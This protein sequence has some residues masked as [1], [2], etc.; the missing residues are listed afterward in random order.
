MIQATS[1][2]SWATKAQPSSV[3]AAIA[4][5]EKNGITA[6]LVTTKEDAKK[7]ILALIPDGSEIMTMTSVTLDELDL[8]KELNES[9]R[10]KSV[11]QT[12]SGMDRNTQKKEMRALGTVP[13]YAIGSV[14]AVTEQG[15]LLI[16]SNTGSQLSAYVYGA[17]KVILVVGTQKIVSNLDS[18]MK[19][20]YEH[21]FPLESERAKKAY[22]VPGSNVSKLLIISK[23]VQ[24]GR[25]SVI[26]VDDVLG[27]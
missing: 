18:G 4:A 8:T 15:E 3:Q 16:A 13:M 5:L 21:S 11:R 2:L 27:F 17:E 19:R 26:F 1:L 14:H 20:V 6:Q 22:G 7:A 12:L 10:F 24:P 9:G 23:E 25:L